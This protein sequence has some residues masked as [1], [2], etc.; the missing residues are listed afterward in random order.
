MPRVIAA[1]LAATLLAGPAV[2]APSL[3]VAGD[4]ERPLRLRVDGAGASVIGGEA[5][6]VRVAVPPGGS[7]D[8]FHATRGGWLAVGSVPVMG[9]RELALWRGQGGAAASTMPPP[10]GRASALRAF[11]VPLLRDGEL[12][13]LAWLEGEAVDR[14]GVRASAWD[15]RVWSA[16]ATVAGPAAGS[17]LA[18]TGAVL[19]DGSWLLA[20]SA[21]DGEDDEIVSSVR[22]KNRWSEPRAVAAGNHVPDTTPALRA[23][24]NG[25]LLVWSRYDGNDYR[26]VLA[27]F[28]GGRWDAGEWAAGP[29]T[30]LPRWEGETLTYRDAA[31]G[32]WVAAR[33]DAADRLEAE[34]AA[35]APP[36]PRPA[37]ERR[38]G[39]VRLLFP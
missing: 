20:W 29:G 6:E 23:D 17:Q 36:E 13:G 39:A 35:P 28:A 24:G 5:A 25:A 11:P 2:A 1:L 33:V 22:R 31:A 10:P 16:P 38:D 19:A 18:L 15:G 8:A 14:F 27:R 4:G 3:L 34:N 32:A 30:I 37:V 9:G 7:I 26:L 21:Y 12:V